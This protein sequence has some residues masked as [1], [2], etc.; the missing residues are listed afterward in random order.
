MAGQI[1]LRYV[2]M[3]LGIPHQAKS[4]FLSDGDTPVVTLNVQHC[5]FVTAKLLFV[6]PQYMGQ[7]DKTNELHGTEQSLYLILS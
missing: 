5:K 6:V 3:N 2:N 4:R 1:F 7:E